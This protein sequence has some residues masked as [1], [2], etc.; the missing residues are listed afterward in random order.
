[1][2]NMINE[3]LLIVGM[4][5]IGLLIMKKTDKQIIHILEGKLFREKK[6]NTKQA[7]AVYMNHIRPLSTI[8]V[9]LGFSGVGLSII[10]LA[11]GSRMFPIFAG[12]SGLFV[13][14]GAWDRLRSFHAADR[15]LS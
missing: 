13:C 11:N 10:T 6:I 1:M 7:A 8:S 3:I 2:Q 9:V 15:D 14:L 12:A 4:I 5:V